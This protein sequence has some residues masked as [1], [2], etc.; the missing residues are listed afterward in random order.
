MPP[1]VAFDAETARLIFDGGNIAG[2]HST[3]TAR[4]TC[5][6]RSKDFR[7]RVLRPTVICTNNP[8]GLPASLAGVR[9]VPAD[10]VAW[11]AM[12]TDS[13]TNGSTD[14][15]PRVCL[16]ADAFTPR[17]SN[18][19]WSMGD[20]ST[21]SDYRYV[22]ICGVPGGTSQLGLPYAQ[23]AVSFKPFV[24]TRF[25]SWHFKNLKMG[26]AGMKTGKQESGFP[27]RWTIQKDRLARAESEYRGI[28]C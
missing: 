23:Q 7:I 15:T 6:G 3:C 16:F 8:V 5:N 17:Q 22:Y 14:G 28:K 27:V 20:A 11:L 2:V 4:L 26:N 24:G 21:N 1:G 10:G 18:N 13:T 19:N 12:K 9:T 25:R